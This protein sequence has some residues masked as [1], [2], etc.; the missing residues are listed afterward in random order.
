MRG[1][2]GARTGDAK[3]MRVSSANEKISVGHEGIYELIEV[4]GQS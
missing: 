3:R 2:G 1:A 4:S